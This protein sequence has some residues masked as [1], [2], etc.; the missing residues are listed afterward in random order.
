MIVDQEGS[1]VWVDEATPR[2]VDWWLHRPD[3]PL[4]ACA[5]IVYRLRS[6]L[7]LSNPGKPRL[8]GE[9]NK[10]REKR[11]NSGDTGEL[12]KRDKSRLSQ[13]LSL[14]ISMV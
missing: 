10:F 14:V 6:Q 1:L 11:W 7:G 13:Y 4:T 8:E 2:N 3:C 12:L 9:W 5:L